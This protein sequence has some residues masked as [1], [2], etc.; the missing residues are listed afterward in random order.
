ML[1]LEWAVPPNTCKYD[2]HYKNPV[3][4]ETFIY[5]SGNQGFFSASP[6]IANGITGKPHTS[7]SITGGEGDQDE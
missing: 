7:F 4:E 1:N 5:Q 6:V 3:L 2:K